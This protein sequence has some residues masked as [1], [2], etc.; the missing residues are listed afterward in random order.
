MFRIAVLSALLLA[1][2]T[3]KNKP[4]QDPPKVPVQPSG[5]RAPTLKCVFEMPSGWTTSAAPTPD[6]IAEMIANAPKLRGRMVLREVVETSVSV[7]AEEQKQRMLASWGSQPDFTLLREDPMGE[8]RL[9]AYQWRPQ[10]SAPIERHLVAVLPFDAKVV[11]AF[12]DDDGATPEK[13][14]LA[15]LSTL[16]CSPK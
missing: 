3:E 1:C 6:H 14:L 4:A 5:F 16:K 7:A 9:F 10:L 2:C 15:T 11:L 8:G 13:Q 12:I